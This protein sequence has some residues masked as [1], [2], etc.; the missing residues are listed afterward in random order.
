MEL[1]YKRNVY[2]VNCSF[3]CALYMC[4]DYDGTFE[5]TYEIFDIKSFDSAV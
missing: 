1:F 5:Y 3:V 2:L 4:R